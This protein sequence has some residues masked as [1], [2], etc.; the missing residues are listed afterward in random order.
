[1][2]TKGNAMTEQEMVP[3]TAEIK[4][5]NFQRSLQFY[6]EVLGFDLLRMSDDDFAV[7]EFN[8]GQFLIQG[9]KDVPEPRGLGVFFR[10][11]VP[12]DIQKYYNL[13]QKRGAKILAK[14]ETMF[15]GL[16]RF[17]VEDPDGY[18]IKFAKKE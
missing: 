3:F 5:P 18:Q 9:E 6:T 13:V 17:Y 4:T 16:S 1:M 11:M 8:G 7:L 15:Y 2:T 14:L 10:F 12:G